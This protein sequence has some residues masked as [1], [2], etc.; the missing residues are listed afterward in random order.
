MPAGG[1]HSM[2]A[3]P[4]P[5]FIRQQYAF[6]A[7]IR[8]PRRNPPPADI[9]DRRLG[10]YRELFFN[11]VEGFLRSSFPVL[12]QLLD[13]QSWLALARDFFA[14]HRCHSPLFLEIPREFL[15]YLD[16]ERG[17]RDSDPPF[18]R[19][20]AHYE[21]VELALSIAEN[22]APAAVEAQGDLLAGKPV[23]SALAW[24]LVYRYPVH[25][26]SPDFQPRQPGEQPVYLLVYRDEADEVGFIELNPVSARLFA[27]LQEHAGRSGRSLLEQIAGEL[28]HPRPDTVVQGG[29]AILEEWRRLG[30]VRGTGLAGQ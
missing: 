16:E 14:R 4:E 8:D 25:R 28:Q 27:L 18:L 12:R 15:A 20:L 24:P 26:I 2:C 11:N 9:E 7:H 17:E 30:I 19:E 21:W 6:A 22:A 29:R 1:V 23:L 5:A 10:I 13:E 3:T